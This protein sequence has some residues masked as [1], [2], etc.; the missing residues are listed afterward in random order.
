MLFNYRIQ[1]KSYTEE[2]PGIKIYFIKKL[3]LNILFSSTIAKTYFDPLF[4]IAYSMYK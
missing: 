4:K 3:N 2:R 1:I